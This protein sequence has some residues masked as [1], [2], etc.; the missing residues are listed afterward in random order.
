MPEAI[1]EWTNMTNGVDLLKNFYQDPTRWT[2]GFENL[3]QLTRL[4]TFY[5][6]KKYFN[7]SSENAESITLDD[8]DEPPRKNVFI[9]RSLLSSYNVFIR[10][11]Y[12]ENRMDKVEYDILT[13]YNTVFTNQINKFFTQLNNHE[14]NTSNI[15]LTE[16]RIDFINSPLPSS[17]QHIRPINDQIENEE[18][19]GKLPFV[20]IY[21]R[22]SPEVCF[23]RV[24]SRNRESESGISLDY[25]KKIHLKYEDWINLLLK[26]NASRVKIVNGDLDK[27]GVFKQL[28]HIFCK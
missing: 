20:I 6:T 12:Q 17:P 10:N 15:P 3:V 4:K 24:Q 21:L 25:L 7:V 28:E 5:A 23:Q 19:D 13:Q 14:T 22:T 18:L 9:E 8:G 11:S 2:F 1:G 16:N 27:P 26:K